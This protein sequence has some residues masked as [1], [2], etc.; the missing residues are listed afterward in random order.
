ME[1]KPEAGR[2][3]RAAWDTLTYGWGREMASQWQGKGCAVAS[4]ADIAPERA[5]GWVYQQ[6]MGKQ[7]KNASGSHDPSASFWV[8]H[9]R[10]L[11][12]W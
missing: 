4:R 3:F 1:G 11:E 9:G 7:G 5:R 10:E 12:P 8:R 6:C 2:L